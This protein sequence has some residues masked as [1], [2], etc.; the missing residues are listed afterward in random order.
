MAQPILERDAIKSHAW[1]QI[2]LI[3]IDRR[4]QII[5]IDRPLELLN[6]EGVVGCRIELH[7]PARY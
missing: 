5:R 4:V 1:Q 2:A 6:I 7:R 3:T